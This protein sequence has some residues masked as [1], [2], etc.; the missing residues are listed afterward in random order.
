LELDLTVDK[1]RRRVTVDPAAGQARIGDRPV[2]FRIVRETEVG[3]ELE[4]EGERVVVTGWPNGWA[5]P[6]SELA[7]NGERVALTEIHREAART[8]ESPRAA[9]PPEPAAAPKASEALEGLAIV[10]PMPGRLLE[11]RV[12]EGD[13][14]R[15][16]QVLLVIEAMKMRNEIVAPVDGVVRGLTAHVGANVAARTTLL[17]IVSK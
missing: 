13:P 3:A 16:G 4:I 17:R 15:V 10:P 8:F 11:L 12:S 1:I 9:A 6:S 7:V 14:V 5:A 2:A